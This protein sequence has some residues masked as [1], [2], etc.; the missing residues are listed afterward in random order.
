MGLSR[1]PVKVYKVFHV[2]RR[3]LKIYFCAQAKRL[4]AQATLAP[5][6]QDI[7]AVPNATQFTE[8]IVADEAKCVFTT[9]LLH[10]PRAATQLCQ[11]KEEL[12]AA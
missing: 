10:R 6:R 12:C 4:A 1:W 5:A 2:P 11:N 7:E 3:S 9:L 8:Q